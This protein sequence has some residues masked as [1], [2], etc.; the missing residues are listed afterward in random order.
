MLIKTIR[1][2]KLTSELLKY[3]DHIGDYIGGCSIGVNYCGDTRSSDYRSSEP[4]APGQGGDGATAPPGS[5]E[6]MSYSYWCL[7]GIMASGLRL[8]ESIGEYIV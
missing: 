1:S 8:V 7:I 3:G 2:S 6:A 4:V 5:S